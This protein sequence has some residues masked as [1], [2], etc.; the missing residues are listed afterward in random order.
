MA[1]VDHKKEIPFDVANNKESP[2][3]KFVPDERMVIF[4]GAYLVT[5][6]GLEIEEQPFASVTLTVNVPE[7]TVFILCVTAPV[8]HK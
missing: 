4:T 7:L 3:Q 1:P 5:D 8:D 2:A 6:N